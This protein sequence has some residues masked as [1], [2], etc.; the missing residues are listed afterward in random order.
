MMLIITAVLFTAGLGALLALII[1]ATAR[2]FAVET[3]SRIE[4]VTEMLPGVNC[5]G[6]GYAGCAD[7]AKAIVE[8]RTLPVQC[9]V[10]TS[11][12]TARIAEYLGITAGEK[13]KVIAVVRCGGS[14]AVTVR[15]PYNGVSDC[16]SAVLVAGGAKGCDFGCVGFASCARACP[17][18][19]IEMRDGLAVVH[20]ELCIGCGKCVDTCPKNL[21]VLT[22]A[23]VDVHV[24]CNSPEKGAVKTKVCKTACIA[25]R[26]C[27]KAADNETQMTVNGF[28][29]ADNY[30]N[31]PISDLVE[32]AKCPT[33]ALRLASKHA[34]GAYEGVSK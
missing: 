24:Y 17:F 22:P 8:G 15:S 11:V 6:C 31:P 7:F 29:V 21:I 9:P 18:D 1:G 3:D 34:A 12:H 26:K 28:L 23:A 2:A 4:T 33:K 32:K 5:G 27:V 13:E 14:C 20:P 19:A 16:R 25:C 10:S 30:S